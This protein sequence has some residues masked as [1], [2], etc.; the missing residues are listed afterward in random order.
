MRLSEMEIPLISKRQHN[1]FKKYL[2]VHSNAEKI[3]AR[4]VISCAIWVIKGGHSWHEIPIR[5]GNYNTIYKRFARWSKKDVFRHIFYS[6]VTKAKISTPAM[7]DS[8]SVKAHR[9]A[10]SLRSDGEEREI[11]RSAGGLTTKIHLLA[12]IEKIPLDFSLTPG[13]MHDSK[14]GERLI[15]INLF[16]FKK[17][18]ADKGYDSDSIREILALRNRVVCIPPKSNRKRPVP[19]D[20]KLYKKR[21]IIEN[22]FSQLKDWRGIAMRYCRCAHM[23]DSAVCLAL[24]SIFLYVH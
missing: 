17:L 12:N 2:P 8:T 4:I 3:D 13:Q 11:G 19:Y 15:K 7:I 23:F 20:R 14:E 24:I 9:T 16:R 5:Y 18:L 22:M 21:S 10:A 6:L 1:R